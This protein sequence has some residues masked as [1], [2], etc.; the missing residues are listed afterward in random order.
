MSR[1]LAVAVAW[2]VRTAGAAV[3]ASA[4]L[5]AQ[6]AP[7]AATK[8]DLLGTVRGR[9]DGRVRVTVWLDDMQ[10]HTM[11]P[12]AEAFAGD[13]GA[14]V[15]RGVP[16]FRRQQWG[17]R[18]VVVTARQPGRV[19]IKTLRGDDAA[20]GGIELVLQPAIELR[21]EL[22]DAETNQPVAGAWVWPSIFGSVDKPQAWLTSPMLPWRAT[23]DAKGQFVL[24]DLPPD[25][26]MKLIAGGPEHARTWIDVA[27]ASQPVRGQLPRGGR[28]RGRVLLPDGKPAARAAVL[29]AGRGAGYGDARTDDEGRFELQGLAP[30]EY[31]VFAEVEDLTVIAVTGLQVHA[32]DD[33]DA[34]VVQ[35]VQGGFITGRLLDAATGKPFVPGSQTDVA[36]YGPARGDGGACEVAPVLPDGT[37]RIR[38]PAGSNRIYLRAAKGYSEP[39]EVVTVVEG[40]ETAVEWRLRPPPQPRAK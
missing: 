2:F 12:I 33:V 13:D 34:Q 39:S 31:K 22:R 37:F 8:A 16:W 14:F 7:E 1:S 21:G 20:I 26:A 11:E 19:A 6:T 9:V 36:M 18:S 3:L 17:S 4:N 40:K 28:I 5:L 25:M 30:D 35:L 24:R 29:A 23:T 15:L 32:G 27:D 38:A 10:K